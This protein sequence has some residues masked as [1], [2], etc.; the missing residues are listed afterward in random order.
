MIKS[1]FFRMRFVHWVGVILLL[2]NAAFFTNNLFGSIIQC[3]IAVVVLIHDQDEKFLGVN[4]LKQ[5]NSYFGLLKDKKISSKPDMNFKFNKELSDVLTSIESFREGTLHSLLQIKQQSDVNHVVSSEILESI[6]S[7]NTQYEHNLDAL[8]SIE[9][10]VLRLTDSY[11]NILS[12]LRTNLSLVDENNKS[13]QITFDK[14]DNMQNKIVQH[15]DNLSMI[16]NQINTLETTSNEV[17]SIIGIVNEIAEQTNLL[18]LNAAI[19]AARAGEAGRGFAVVADEV[20]KLAEKTK[21]SLVDIKEV[22]GRITVGV[23]TTNKSI[24]NEVSVLN[25]VLKASNDN[26]E[27]IHSLLDNIKV[28]TEKMSSYADQMDSL[29]NEL[30]SIEG[31]VLDV[32]KGSTDVLHNNF[33]LIEEKAGMVSVSAREINNCINEFKF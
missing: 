5:L 15:S 33:K 3:I 9:H 8:N 19:E 32:K 13:A 6:E 2:A 21:V 16:Q 31:L 30:H 11:E 7:A 1:L 26:K 29:D 23:D 17:L 20:R 18:A 4:T 24:E 25:D 27:S 10:N 12:N 28:L 22:V 14:F